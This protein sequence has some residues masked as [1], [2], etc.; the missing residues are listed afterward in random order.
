MSKEYI[1]SGKKHEQY[2]IVKV[3]IDVEK[4]KPDIYEYSGKKYLTFD[5][6]AKREVD[7]YGKSHSVSVFIPDQ[8]NDNNENV[9]PSFSSGD[10]FNDDI[11]F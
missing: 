4:A 2:D 5:V 11:P 10:N 7:Q 9:E 6:A 1:G 8:Q 3:T